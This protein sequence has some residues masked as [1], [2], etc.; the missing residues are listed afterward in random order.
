MEKNDGQRHLTLRPSAPWQ[1]TCSITMAPTLNTFGPH[2]F[3]PL[4]PS[5]SPTPIYHGYDADEA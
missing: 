5:L 4:N 2:I 1:V 3:T